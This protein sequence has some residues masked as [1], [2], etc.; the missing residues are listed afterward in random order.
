MMP[1]T[2]KPAVHDVVVLVGGLVLCVALMAGGTYVALRTTSVGQL[3]SDTQNTRN[4]PEALAHVL[5]GYGDP[6]T[7]VME[8][9]PRVLTVLGIVISVLVGGIVAAFV[10]HRTTWIGIA[11]VLPLVVVVL[12]AQPTAPTSWLFAFLWLIAA[13]VA[14]SVVLRWRFR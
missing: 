13:F 14:G 4:D 3:L 2:Y 9:F 10:S 12:L 11:S 5:S 6:F 1:G 7:M 8:T